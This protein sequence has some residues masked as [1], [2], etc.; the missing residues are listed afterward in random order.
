M[1]STDFEPDP[2]AF[3]AV[4]KIATGKRAKVAVFKGRKEK[5]VSG[6]KREHLMINK[7]GKVVSRKMNLGF[8]ELWFPNKN[9]NLYTVL[10]YFSLFLLFTKFQL[11]LA[12]LLHFPCL[13]Q[14]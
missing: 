9:V 12:K 10:I 11:R 8:A 6:L 4:S 13:P 3:E 1:S 14:H 2:F 5:T 7:R